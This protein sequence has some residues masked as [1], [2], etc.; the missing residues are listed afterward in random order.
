MK[1]H[2]VVEDSTTEYTLQ[3]NGDCSG[4]R[5]SRESKLMEFDLAPTEPRFTEYDQRHMALYLSLLHAKAEGTS[6]TVIARNV[7]GID[8]VLE[9][10]RA[11]TVIESHHRRALWLSGPGSQHVLESPVEMA[12]RTRK[13]GS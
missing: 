5:K 10:D 9:P 1:G 6:D 11:K 4:F 7:F 8:A 13:H 12:L 2:P 3:M